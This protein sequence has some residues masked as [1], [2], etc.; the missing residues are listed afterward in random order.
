MTG[1]SV[2]VPTLNEEKNIAP[3]VS[4]IATSLERSEIPYEIIFVDDNST[5]NTIEEIKILSQKFPLL[6]FNKKG[7]TGKAFSLLEGFGK[8]KYDVLA[9]IDA[10]L[11]YPPEAIAEMV[12]M[13]RNDNFDFVVAKRHEK[14]ISFKRKFLSRGFNLLF[15]KLMHSLNFDVQSGLKVFKKEIYE[16]IK[17]TPSAWT[18]DMEFLIKS[19]HGGY[20]VGEFPIDFEKRTEGKA[21]I[22][23]IKASAEIG[24]NAVKLKIK[25]PGVI[26]FHPETEKTKG[27]GFHFKGHE[28]VHH[29][30]LHIHETAF[31]RTLTFQTVLIFGVLGF[32]GFGFFINWHQTILITV[33]VITILYFLD[34]IFNMFLIFR[35]FKHNPE[36]RITNEEIQEKSDNTWPSYTIF[37]PL[38]HET[39]VLPQFISAMNALDYPKEKLQVMIVLEED[40]KESISQMKNFALPS[41]FEVSIVPHSFPK[42]KPKALNFALKHAHGE[43]C[44]I[45]DAEDIPESDQL[46]KTIVAFEKLGDNVAC[47]QAKL[48][49]YNPHQNILT[50]IFTAE[51]S[52]W[53]DL[54]LTGMQSI[55]APIPLGGTSNHF[56]T[57]TVRKLKGWDSFNVTEDCD[58][59]MRLVKN[60]YRTA[61]VDSTTFEEANSGIVNW[62]KQ[63][64]RWIKGYIQTYLVHSRAPHKLPIS[65][66]LIVGGKVFSMLVNP[67]MWLITIAYFAWRSSIGL[68]IESF[69]PTPVLYMGVMSFIFGNFLYLYYYMIGCAKREQYALIKYAFLT[70]FYW[71][72]MSI[73]AWHAVYEVIRNP[74]YWDKTKHGLHLKKEKNINKIEEFIGHGL[75]DK[76]ILTK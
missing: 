23:L 15:A 74:H 52:V 61:I 2:V 46:K 12:K 50:R 72:G 21:K 42:T 5:D 51:Y 47:I 37:C 33:A 19:I 69:F 45:Y 67:V 76:T 65:F 20:H 68:F 56:K 14:L 34:L 49:F 53:F 22:H 29:N 1:V 30:N 36:L 16:R 73:A 35:T 62:F 48:N 39:Q 43:Y 63:R 6:V 57:E 59:G 18:F 17:I 7:N 58:L 8:A 3:L 44:V 60:G 26:P 25:K 40:D 70:P 32:L 41:F 55:N 75:V 11:Q 24:W 10:D 9:M 66:Q 13:I 28:F 27:Q 4:R 71:L 64:T 38:Y 54:I 31:F